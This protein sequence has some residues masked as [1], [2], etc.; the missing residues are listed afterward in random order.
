ME[1][2]VIP[3]SLL[4]S[5]MEALCK[6]DRVMVIVAVVCRASFLVLPVSGV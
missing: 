1:E 6:H 4:I 2:G 5:E 3:P